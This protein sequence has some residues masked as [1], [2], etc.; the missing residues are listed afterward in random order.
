MTIPF[1]IMK[2]KVWNEL[3]SQY[4]SAEGYAESQ[5][6]TDSDWKLGAMAAEQNLPAASHP[7]LPTVRVNAYHA[8]RFAVWLG[9]KD[10]S[11]LPSVDQ[12]DSA[13][14]YILWE[15]MNSEQRSRFPDGPFRGPWMSGTTDVCVDRRQLGPKPVGESIDDVTITGCTD[16]AGNVLELTETLMN[17]ARVGE[18][19]PHSEK[20][21]AQVLLRG[22]S[23]LSSNP[24]RWDDIRN[25]TEFPDA[26]GYDEI[27]PTVG[28]R[29][30]IETTR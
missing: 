17:G 23:Y 27:D 26:I 5:S 11:H 14:G 28:F 12:W 22:R 1:Y 10:L 24:L 8:H 18:V 20:S 4:W 19:Q 30:V 29:V 9:E 7:K 2:Q 13:S 25:V 3:F 15:S 16:M 21:Q 6:T